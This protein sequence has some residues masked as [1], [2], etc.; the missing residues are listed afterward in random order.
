M[1]WRLFIEEYS[2]NL[3]Y[4]K[5]IKNV[6]AK[7]LSRSGILNNPMDEEHFTEALHSEQLCVG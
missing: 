6:A 4:I 1:Q 2:P 7:T 5:G 3:R